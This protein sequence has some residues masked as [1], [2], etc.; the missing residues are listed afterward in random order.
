MKKIILS[1]AAFL[2]SLALVARPV[3]IEKALHVAGLRLESAESN[4]KHISEGSQDPA[5]YIFNRQG[6]GF[7]IISADDCFSPI[8]GYSDKGSID[9]ARIPSNMKFWLGQ[10][11][12][13]VK[14]ARETGVTPVKSIRDKW[15][16]PVLPATKAGS[17]K[18]LVIPTWYQEIP[19]NYYCPRIKNESGKSMTGCVATAISMVMRY[20]EWPPCGTGTLPGYHMY[21]EGNSYTGYYYIPGHDL[22]HEYKWSVMPF[23]DIS[24]SNANYRPREGDKQIAWLMYDCA[25]MMEAEFSY[26]GT[27]AF[28]HLIPGRMYEYMHYKRATYV[29]KKDYSGDWVALL[30]SQIDRDLPVIYGGNDPKNGGHQFVVCGYDESDNLYVNWGWGG[31]ADGYYAITSF[32]PTSTGFRFTSEHDAI[33][34][35]EPDR[36][37]TPVPVSQSEPKSIVPEQSD[38]PEEPEYDIP[39]TI[40]L[41]AGN[42]G[43]YEYYGLELLGGSINANSSFTMTAGIIKNPTKTAYGGYFRFDQCSYDGSFIGT[44]GYYKKSG[45]VQKLTVN[46]GGS[47]AISSGQ[48][49]KASYP[50]ALGDKIILS[51]STVNNSSATWSQVPWI[52]DEY[53]LGEYP[54]ISMAFIDPESKDR[55][56]NTAEFYFECK[57]KNLGNFVRADIGFEDGSSE[58]VILEL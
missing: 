55:V 2:A 35:L 48:S 45:S 24:S 14:E 27:G 56:V 13:A 52:N 30:K 10:V 16:T 17:A 53:T 29:M 1:A 3:G 4:L 7:A 51:T 22:G 11:S 40:Y 5:Y 54:M 20:H 19:Y 12:A 36:S 18:L 25:V 23:A 28:S 44:L 57:V 8:L 47:A 58:V 38:G 31:D 39:S 15:E 49:C 9:P 32:A 26:E 33:V 43:Y 41:Q 37:Y 34:N 6:G 21:Y 50:I 42:Q 46:A